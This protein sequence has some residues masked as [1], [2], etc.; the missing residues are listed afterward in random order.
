MRVRELVLV[1][2]LLLR[3]FDP[4][5]FKNQWSPNR[6]PFFCVQKLLE[7]NSCLVYNLF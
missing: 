5:Q 4:N 1:K 7:K 2:L 6:A 3:V